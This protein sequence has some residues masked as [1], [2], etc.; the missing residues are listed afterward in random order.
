M[1]LLAW[2]SP[3][4]RS[5]WVKA[6]HARTAAS[7]SRPCA[8]TSSIASTAACWKSSGRPCRSKAYPFKKTHSESQG[9]SR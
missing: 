9:S 2:F 8:L 6:V 1:G 3:A 7:A 5:L 4:F